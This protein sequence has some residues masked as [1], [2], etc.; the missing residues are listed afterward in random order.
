MAKIELLYVSFYTVITT[1]VPIGLNVYLLLYIPLNT[2][3]TTTTI[4]PDVKIIVVYIVKYGN[5][6]GCSGCI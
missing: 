2:V 1:N 6:N 5:N 4:G 3:I